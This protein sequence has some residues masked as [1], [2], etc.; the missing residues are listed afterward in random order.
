MNLHIGWEG[1]T[2]EENSFRNLGDDGVALWSDE[3]ADTNVVIKNNLV[4]PILAGIVVYG[5]HDNAIQGNLIEDTIQ[6]GGIRVQ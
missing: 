1:V 4:L 6:G 3:Q 2:I 5:G